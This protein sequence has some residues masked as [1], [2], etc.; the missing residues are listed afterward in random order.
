MKDEGQVR[1]V[2]GMAYFEAER[3]DDAKDVFR[4][5]MSSPD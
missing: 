2:M 1:M 3:F 5:A 4:A